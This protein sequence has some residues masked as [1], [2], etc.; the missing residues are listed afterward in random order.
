MPVVQP[1]PT[2]GHFRE[3]ILDE[4]LGAVVVADPGDRGVTGAEPGVDRRL[5]IDQALDR[6]TPKQRSTVVLRYYDDL[7][8][9]ETAEVLGVSLGTVKS[10]TH[11]ALRRM[12]ESSPELAGLL[13][14]LSAEGSR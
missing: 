6:L 2:G 8:E 7:S 3:R 10:T 12:R 5:L 13:G 4:V 9:R 1:A 11:D 14:D